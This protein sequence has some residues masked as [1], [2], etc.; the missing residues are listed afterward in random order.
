VTRD[1]R[2]R[3]S[4]SNLRGPIKSSKGNMTQQ[5]EPGLLNSNFSTLGPAVVLVGTK[6]GD[7]RVRV[8]LSN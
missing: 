5:K 7:S 8:S 4:P 1:S 6:T 2:V 3:I